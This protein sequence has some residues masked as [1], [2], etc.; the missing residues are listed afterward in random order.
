MKKNKLLTLTGKQS[1]RFVTLIAR[2]KVMARRFGPKVAALGRRIIAWAE[3][4]PKPA[5]MALG[6]IPMILGVLIFSPKMLLT[7]LI[8]VAMCQCE[9][10]LKRNGVPIKA[11]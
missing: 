11:S 6:G 1:K 4:N 2:L 9:N 7:G 8:V 10:F 3:R 5:L